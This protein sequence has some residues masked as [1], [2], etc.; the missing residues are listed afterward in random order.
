[1]GQSRHFDRVLPTSG[2]V[3]ETDIP[4]VCAQE[5]TVSASYSSINSSAAICVD[6]RTVSPGAFA[7]L[8]LMTN[9]I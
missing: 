1:L 8:V 9:R 7:V 4:L 3:L 5:Q 6:C 2:L